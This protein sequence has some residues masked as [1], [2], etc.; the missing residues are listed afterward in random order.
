[1]MSAARRIA[2][3][4][5]GEAGAQLALRLQSAGVSVSLFSDRSAEEIRSGAIMS[6]QCV[7]GSARA[8]QAPL[9]VA[10]TD[11]DAR[12]V[13]IAGIE[14]SVT[15]MQPWSASLERPALSVDQRVKVSDWIEQFH[16]RG[17]DLRVEKVGPAQLE[18]LAAA[19]EL[20]IVATGKADLSQ[21]FATDRSRTPHDRPQRASAVAY[22]QRTAENT[23]DSIRLH[24]KPGIGEFFT[25]P[26]VTTSGECQMLVFEG[27]PGG[28][29]D[30]WASVSTPEAHLERGLGLLRQ[31][32]PEE[33]ARFDGAQLTDDGAVLRGRVSPIVRTPVGELASGGAVMGLGDA[34]ILNDPLTGQGSNNATIAADHYCEAIIRRGNRPFDRAWMT[35]TFEEYWRAWGKWSTVWTNDLLSG[36]RPD[37]ERLL[38]EA[39]RHPSLGAAIAAGFDDPRT[40][41]PWWSDAHAAGAFI[42]ACAAEDA[43]EFDVRDFRNALGQFATGVTVVT[44]L[45][46]RGDNVGVTANSFASVSMDP[47]LVLWC[48]GKH[49]R[50]LSDFETATHYAINVLASDQHS[51][52]RQFAS[53]ATD[54]FQGVPVT[55][56]VAG[57]PLI[58]DAIA[59]FECRT[60]ARH[61]AGDHVVYIGEVERYSY[62]HDA[63][64][65]FHGGG[66]RDTALHESVTAG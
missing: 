48:P 18:V 28:P 29:M 62:R 10:A 15:G 1:M 12:S 65:V 63:P 21:V 56:G 42:E 23:S 49:L 36:L 8:V 5:A 64:L 24:L 20:V 39:S 35:H 25:F 2:V 47:P 30:A 37:Q 14:V 4:G 19:Y 31:H 17:G 27:V 55:E 58:T 61:D 32:F 50:S 38:V 60:V 11:V 16:G 26:G 51:L 44:T 45:T 33:G 54:K 57:V 59:T 6:S 13:E 46:A 3:V 52:S 53:A 66:Y 7:F 22:V 41:F 9:S 43:A 34:V 40:L